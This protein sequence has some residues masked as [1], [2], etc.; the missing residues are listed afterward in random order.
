MAFIGMDAN[1]KAEWF[2]KVA[3]WGF[4]LIC[5]RQGELDEDFIKRCLDHNVVAI[6]TFD[7]DIAHLLQHNDSIIIE[8][9]PN[10]LRR[11]LFP[12]KLPKIA[13]SYR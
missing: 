1:L 4:D 5:A 2:G 9:Y 12:K 7:S 11:K 10:V 6:L 8:R 3:G 13:R